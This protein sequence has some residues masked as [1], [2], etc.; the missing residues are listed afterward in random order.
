MSIKIVRLEY[1]QMYRNPQ[2]HM[3]EKIQLCYLYLLWLGIDL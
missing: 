1:V 3:G 2:L